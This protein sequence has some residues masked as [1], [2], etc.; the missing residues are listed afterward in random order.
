MG[1]L[2]KVQLVFHCLLGFKLYVQFIEGNEETGTHSDDE[3]QLAEELR[4]TNVMGDDSLQLEQ[5]ICL[6]AFVAI[7]EF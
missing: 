4:E 2:S 3:V 6:L 5:V 1:R 7:K